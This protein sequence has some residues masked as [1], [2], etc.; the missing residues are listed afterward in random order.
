[1]VYK[2]KSGTPWYKRK[3]WAGKFKGATRARY[4]TWSK[5]NM[6]QVVSDVKM[7]KS[8]INVE[9]KTTDLMPS[10]VSVGRYNGNT[11]TTGSQAI[12]ITPIIHQGDGGSQRNGNSLKL[13]S[14]L[15][16]F[17]F[18][19]Q[20]STINN[21]RIRYTVVRIPE[22]SENEAVGDLLTQ[23]YEDNPFTGVVDYFSNRYSAFYTKFKV[24][25]TGTVAMP[26]DSL[27]GT[28]QTK[29]FK[30]PLK[31]GE[32]LKYATNSSNITTKNRYVLFLTGSDGDIAN[33]AQS[34]TSVYMNMKYF[35]TDN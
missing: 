9:K 35:Y 25:K 16:Q 21:Q 24:V 28:Q 13:I 6:T 1:M 7:L 29:Q 19:Q 30:V 33:T 8:L 15:F 32:H 23:F 14:A 10:A 2:K 3:T 17:Q 31:L 27:A 26:T 5:P 18:I 11:S 20:P 12:D 22:N 34:G 4:G